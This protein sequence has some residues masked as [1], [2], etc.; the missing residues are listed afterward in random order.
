MT[1]T[2]NKIKREKEFK[3]LTAAALPLLGSSISCI[4]NKWVIFL[5]WLLGK[6][7]KERERLK[8]QIKY[9]N[10]IGK[11]FIIAGAPLSL[12]LSFSFSASMKVTINNFQKHCGTFFCT[13]THTEYPPTG[14][15]NKNKDK[16]RPLL[17]CIL[18][19]NAKLLIT[20]SCGK[21]I[22]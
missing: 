13:R 19:S 10:I 1:Q 18:Q 11:E 17:Y 4:D 12:S 16:L 2:R 22:D 5:R 6:E 9:L 20:S 7:E 15:K 14:S 21:L 3:F 8:I